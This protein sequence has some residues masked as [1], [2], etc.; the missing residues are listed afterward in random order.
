MGTMTVHAH[1]WSPAPVVTRADTIWSFLKKF[2]WR[3][4]Q[5]HLWQEKVWIKLFENISPLQQEFWRAAIKEKLRAGLWAPE[6][7]ITNASNTWH[8]FQNS[9]SI[10]TQTFLPLVRRIETKI[11]L[12][13]QSA[14]MTWYPFQCSMMEPVH[15]NAGQRIERVHHCSFLPQVQCTLAH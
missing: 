4:C 7:R 10:I 11:F 5:K 13:P 2:I 6:R 15:R 9:S 3:L 12:A 1:S 8:K 14:L